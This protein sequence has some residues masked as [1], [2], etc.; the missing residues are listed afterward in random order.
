MYSKSLEEHVQHTP[1]AC[2][3]QVE[4][5]SSTILEEGFKMLES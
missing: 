3:G 2:A 1:Q 5:F 4:G